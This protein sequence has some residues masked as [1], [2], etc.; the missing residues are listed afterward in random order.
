[1]L[2]VFKHY[3]ANI[4]LSGSV[5]ASSEVSSETELRSAVKS[6]FTVSVVRTSEDKQ[7][8]EV[9]VVYLL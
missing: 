6:I 2:Y 4:M 9:S 5:S 3:S 7:K 1:M 8:L